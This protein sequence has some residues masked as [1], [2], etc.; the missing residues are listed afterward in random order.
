MEQHQHSRRSGSDIYGESK[1]KQRLKRIIASFNT[2]VRSIHL[3]ESGVVVITYGTDD[4][5]VSVHYHDA[6][7][8]AGFRFDNRNVAKVI[9]FSNG[10]V[11][12]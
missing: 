12:R 11:L 1:T 5:H 4:M 6:Q 7:P 2:N 3:H 9:P 8:R 10:S